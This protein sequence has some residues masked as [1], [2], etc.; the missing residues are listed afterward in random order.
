MRAEQPEHRMGEHRTKNIEHAE[1]GRLERTALP[2]RVLPWA[3]AL[4]LFGLALWVRLYRLEWQ[5]LWLD[6]G[7]TW[8]TVTGN[9]LGTLVRDLVRPTQAYP[10]YHLVM[11][12]DTRLLG[13]GEWALRLPSALAGAI[14]VPALFA[15]GRE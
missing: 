14:A 12:L 8:A 15:L 10:L 9:R 2:D 1:G 6:E 4:V 11:K 3:V 13:D 7:A 5:P